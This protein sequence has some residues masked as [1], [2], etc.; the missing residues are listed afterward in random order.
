MHIIDASTAAAIAYGF[1]KKGQGGRY[2]FIFDLGGG[3]FNVSILE[4]EN[5]IFEVL[6]TA[7]D[8]NLGGEDFTNRMVNHFIDEFKREFK[9]DMGNDQLAVRRLR[10]ACELAK[11]TLSS[12]TEAR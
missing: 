4:I 6:S 9:K 7:G 2:V 3:T 11:H 1:D 10:A 12:S 8:N 5:G